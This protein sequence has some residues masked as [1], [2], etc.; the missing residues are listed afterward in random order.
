[1]CNE[2]RSM[3]ARVKKTHPAL[4]HGGYSATTILPGESAAEFDKLHRD[5]IAELNPDGVLENDIVATMAMALWRKQNLGT[6][7]IAERVRDRLEQLIEEKDPDPPSNYEYDARHV[8]PTR[9]AEAQTRKEF[10]VAYELV[11]IGETATVDRL[12][13]DLEVLDRLDAIIDKGLKRL[14]FV[15]GLKS[16]SAAP[17][18]APPKRLSG[19]SKA[20]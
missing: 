19:P 9:A 18:S 20:A 16:I 17:S 11:E 3:S 15:R 4:K 12:M 1:M 10:G 6:F 8:E 5:L 14:L 13:K 2:E 7:R